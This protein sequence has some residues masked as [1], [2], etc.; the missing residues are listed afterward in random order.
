[1][2][3]CHAG[4]TPQAGRTVLLTTHSMEEAD[5]LGDRIGIMS[6][7]KLVALGSSLRL[8][9]KFG[10]AAQPRVGWSLDPFGMSATQAVLQALMG[11]EAWFFTRLSGDVVDAMK[12]SKGLEFVWRG[13]SALPAASSEIF[14]HV[15]ESYYCMPLPTYAFEW[16][17]DKGAVVPNASNL[18]KLS[19]DLANI[20]KQRRAW[21]RTDNVLIPWGA[22]RQRPAAAAARAAV[23]CA[24]LPVSPAAN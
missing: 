17:P 14:A 3:T 12:K 2:L 15:F 21:F 23:N 20:A 8:K 16:G 7:G 5:A 6:A 11:M 1:M 9:D 4:H 13:S 24:C 22:R 10:E 19:H 18:E